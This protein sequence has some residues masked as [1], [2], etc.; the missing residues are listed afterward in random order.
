MN[1]V[2]TFSVDFLICCYGRTP[3]AL[4]RFSILLTF[5]LFLPD[6]CLRHPPYIINHQANLNRETESHSYN[7]RGPKCAGNRKRGGE[8]QVLASDR[9]AGSDWTVKE[10]GEA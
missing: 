2:F 4:G 1:R 3:P 9:W 5:S 7:S 8:G 6:D 10:E